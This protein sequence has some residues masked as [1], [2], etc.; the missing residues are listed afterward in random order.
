[1]ITQNRMILVAYVVSLLAACGGG[2]GGDSSSPSSSSTPAA[3]QQS[4]TG[5]W[6]GSMKDGAGTTT[7]VN[8]VI[9]P[10]GRLIFFYGP[11]YSSGGMQADA[12]VVI[13]NISLNPFYETKTPAND[14]Y[15]QVSTSGKVVTGT[16]LTLD[17]TNGLWPARSETFTM[18]ASA[19]YSSPSSLALVTGSYV[20]SGGAS[21]AIAANGALTGNLIR[22]GQT[23]SSTGTVS[24]INT[25][26]NLY[27]VSLTNPCYVGTQTGYGYITYI[28][29]VKYFV[30]GVA[31]GFST[32]TAYT[33]F[34]A[35]HT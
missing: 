8:G 31:N 30:M 6:T 3:T 18:T 28:G 25:S 4:A 10:D 21:F 2:G 29:G 14:I 9:A 12:S 17:L 13:A 32:T 34:Y 27:S 15:S 16:S 5:S 1:M 24:L 19:D 35:G 33:I 11:A 20:T 22:S 7:V 23:C 26:K